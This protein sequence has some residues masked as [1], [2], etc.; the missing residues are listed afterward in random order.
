VKREAMR[1]EESDRWILV[2]NLLRAVTV[3]NVP[4]DNQYAGKPVRSLSVPGGNGHVGEQAEAHRV[5]GKGMMSWRPREHDR[6][7]LRVGERGIDRSQR[8]SGSKAGNGIAVRAADRIRFNGSAALSAELVHE[9][10]V[11]RA[12]GK[13]QLIRR[14]R[15]EGCR[16]KLILQ[17][18]VLQ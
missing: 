16:P 2:E 4:V 12:V 14:G 13:R 5:G 11:I 6:L 8:G 10:D 9:P 3:M 18:A 15:P 17:T 7:A 1:G